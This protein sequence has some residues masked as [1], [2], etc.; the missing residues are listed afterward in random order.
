VTMSGLHDHAAYTGVMVAARD[1]QVDITLCHVQHAD[2]LIEQY[3]RT[4]LE[5]VAE[6]QAKR[7]R[8]GQPMIYQGFASRTISRKR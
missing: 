1:T 4:D 8:C 2:G 3:W 7:C 5:L 6:Q